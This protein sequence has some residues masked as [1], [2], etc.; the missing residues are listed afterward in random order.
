MRASI[1]FFLVLGV[2]A[3]F[4][5]LVLFSAQ[6]SNAIADRRNRKY[7]LRERQLEKL[8]R[9][10]RELAYERRDID[11]SLSYEITDKIGEFY[12]KDGNNG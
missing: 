9:E 3:A 8:V 4:A 11:S 6:I 12:D 1:A 7:N 5:L 10:I 2:L